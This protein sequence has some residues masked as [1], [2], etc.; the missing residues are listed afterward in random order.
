MNN[1]ELESPS[2]VEK[3]CAYSTISIYGNGTNS[4][5]RK[6]VITGLDL[7][8]QKANSKML[9]HTGLKYYHTHN[10]EIFTKVKQKYL[11]S[12]WESSNYE[13]QV[14]Q[15]AHNIRNT[16]NNLKIKQ[17][18]LYSINQLTLFDLAV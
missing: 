3:K 13:V 15:I 6:C 18:R 5:N 16:H 17:E 9:S 4:F 14:M 12:K 2:K 11:T 7:S 1:Y 10:K 8:M